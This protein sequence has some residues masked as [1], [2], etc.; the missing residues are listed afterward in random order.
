LEIAVLALEE[1]SV[2]EGASYGA[3]TPRAGESLNTAIMEDSQP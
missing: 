3:P 1:G 2:F